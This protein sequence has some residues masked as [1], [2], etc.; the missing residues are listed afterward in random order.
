VSAKQKLSS[1][2]SRGRL[3]LC[4]VLLVFLAACPGF[5]R[6]DSLEDAARALARKAG[7]SL[8][9]V[10]VSYDVRN[11]SSLSG[12]EFS[13]LS[14]AFQEELLRHGAR[15]SPA[16][17]GAALV[18]TVT[19]NPH[20]YIGIVQIR[21]KESSENVMEVLG[22]I[23]GAPAAELTYGLAVHKEF[24]FSQDTP[25]LDVVLEG[26]SQH[27]LA[28]EPQGISTYE[29]QGDHWVLT[30][31][32]HLPVRRSSDRQP[33][34]FL[35]FGIDAGTAYL[36]GEM[37]NVSILDAKGWKCEKC[38]EPIFPVSSRVITG[39][40]TETW[41]SAAQMGP[42]QATRIIATGQDGLARLYED[43]PDPV[44][45]F[46]GWGSEIAS[47]HSGCGSGW[48]LLVTG[49][50]DW[51]RADTIQAVEIQ[52][53]QAQPVSS[54]IELAG[55]VTALHALATRFAGERSAGG[56]A[57]AV[58][59]NLQTGRYEAYRVSITCPN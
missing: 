15:I 12:R 44:A 38:D 8:H 58:V 20:A 2:R 16:D 49:K 52:E 41:I 14:S 26:D 50:G 17:A 45:A 59:R 42:E 9:G 27:A 40:K 36:P 30:A 29:L 32:G 57:L 10:S 21:R 31:A 51:T 24:L 4:L 47:V 23:E 48:Q 6:A 3:S 54:P 35:F 56:S 18:L 43:G 5:C 39:K 7:S 55:A 28:L 53:R 1:L 25:I 46:S 11:L 33:R 34:G 19:E 22:P 37:C 13:N